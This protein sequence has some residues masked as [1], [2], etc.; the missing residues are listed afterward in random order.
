MFS[1]NKYKSDREVTYTCFVWKT[2]NSYIYWKIRRIGTIY[3]GAKTFREI[4]PISHLIFQCQNIGTFRQLPRHIE[5]FN[6]DKSC[7]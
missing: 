6:L 5:I 7:R 3:V 1:L 2:P 4:Y